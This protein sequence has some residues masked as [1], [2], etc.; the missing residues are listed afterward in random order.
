MLMKN[1]TRLAPDETVSF[2]VRCSFFLI[3]FRRRTLFL[4]HQLKRRYRRYLKKEYVLYMKQHYP[5]C[6]ADD[7]VSPTITWREQ[8]TYI[9]SVEMLSA[10]LD[11]IRQSVRF[12]RFNVVSIECKK[13]TGFFNQYT[14]KIYRDIQTQEE[15]VLAHYVDIIV[16]M[17]RKNLTPMQWGYLN[18]AESHIALLK[19]LHEKMEDLIKTIEKDLGW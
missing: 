4:V 16:D 11:D 17:K 18:D 13:E 1:G 14:A 9:Y 5:Y 7:F 6:D 15:N 3:F 2:S 8:K 10:F 12:M 19:G